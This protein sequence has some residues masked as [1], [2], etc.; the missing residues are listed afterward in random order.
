L[1]RSNRLG[2]AHV[3]INGEL[4]TRVNATR[5]AAQT[6]L[7]AAHLHHELVTFSEAN[8]AFFNDTGARFN[9][10]AA[11]EAYRRTLAWFDRYAGPR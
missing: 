6:A 3:G 2:G 9:A 8:H 1:C 4:D 10:P 7:E 5:D 11:A